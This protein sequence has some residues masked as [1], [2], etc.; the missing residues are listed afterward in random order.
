MNIR[1]L[2]SAKMDIKE[3]FLFYEHQKEGL[4][5]YFIEAIMFDIESLNTFAG[6]HS[7]HLSRYYRLLAKRFP[8]AIYYTI[9]QNEIRVYAVIDCRRD[10]A[11]IRNKLQYGFSGGGW[12]A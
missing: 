10:P 6:V 7:I 11:W 3:G 12:P 5:Q 9:E 8:F 2:E 1:I 4:G